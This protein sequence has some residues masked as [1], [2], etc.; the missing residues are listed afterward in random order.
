[1]STFALNLYYQSHLL[2][3]SRIMTYVGDWRALL[4]RSDAKD[5]G[6]KPKEAGYDISKL[7]SHNSCLT[8]LIDTP[9]GGSLVRRL[10]S[11]LCQR[12]PA[13]C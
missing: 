11:K 4:D 2:A 1:M 7:V 8:M 6:P 3:S 5:G 12:R 10:R 9:V 13:L